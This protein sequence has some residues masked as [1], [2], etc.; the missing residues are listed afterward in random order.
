MPV[1]PLVYVLLLKSYHAKRS[2]TYVLCQRIGSAGEIYTGR[3][4]QTPSSGY[5]HLCQGHLRYF[6]SRLFTVGFFVRVC[7][8]VPV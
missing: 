7:R 4:L 1:S 6:F 3:W 8:A 2:E 5:C